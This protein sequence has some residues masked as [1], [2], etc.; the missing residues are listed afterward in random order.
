[1]KA[2]APDPF[3]H[4]SGP[5]SPRAIRVLY[6]AADAWAADGAPAVDV[7]PAV[8]RRI[9]HRGVGAARRTWLLLMALELEPL[10]TLRARRPFSFLP[11]D[12]RRR[13]LARFEGSRVGPCRRGVETLRAWVVEARGGGP[14]A[15]QS[16]GA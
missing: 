6:N 7:L 16:S 9:L 5:L 3:G 2:G 11:R 14:G 8:E 1:M 10:L 4:R 15:P 13:T 12:E